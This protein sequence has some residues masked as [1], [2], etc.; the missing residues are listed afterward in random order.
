MPHSLVVDVVLLGA[1]LQQVFL[2]TH[3]LKR[4]GLFKTG[5]GF[6]GD[7]YKRDNN[8]S[9]LIKFKL[10][11]IYTKD[12]FEV[13]AIVARSK[14]NRNNTFLADGAYGNSMELAYRRAFDGGWFMNFST[15]YTTSSSRQVGTFGNT[16][17]FD[18]R[19][20][21]VNTWNLSIT[22]RF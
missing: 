10:I 20:S 1:Q 8:A 3:A 5:L 9:E 4:L 7:F 14:G 6:T 13:S 19:N 2:S 12:N 15:S 17:S 11:S 21:K 18:Q 22:K 16:S